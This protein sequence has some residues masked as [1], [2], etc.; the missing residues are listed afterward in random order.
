MMVE[1]RDNIGNYSW[2]S[3]YQVRTYSFLM[4]ACSAASL[5]KTLNSESTLS[6]RIF[7]PPEAVLSFPTVYLLKK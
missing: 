3:L 7:P 1:M 5:Q 2:R 4:S 6:L